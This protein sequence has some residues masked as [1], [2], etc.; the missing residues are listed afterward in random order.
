MKLDIID[1]SLES[2]VDSI[3]NMVHPQAEQKNITFTVDCQDGGEWFL[4]DNLRISQRS[5]SIFWA[6]AVKFSP[7]GGKVMLYIRP[8]PLDEK[9]TELYFSV[10]DN[11]IGAAREDVERIFNS[12]K[13]GIPG[14]TRNYGGTGLGLAISDRLIRM[15][16]GKIDL[17]SAVGS[18]SDFHFALVLEKGHAENEMA[19]NLV[20]VD[21]HRTPC[22]PCGG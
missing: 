9:H 15:M 21:F 22:A 1:F 11:G 20:S 13:G 5:S 4:G 10:R 8:K 7:A 17:D 2:M 6:V 12:F 19:R 18:G 3:Q 14:T 16:G